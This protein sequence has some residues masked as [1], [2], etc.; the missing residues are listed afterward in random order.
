MLHLTAYA[1]YIDVPL[2]VMVTN[3]H[4][5]N[6]LIVLVNLMQ[7]NMVPEQGLPICFCVLRLFVSLMLTYT[8]LVLPCLSLGLR[9]SLSGCVWVSSFSR[10][11]VGFV[12]AQHVKF[13]PPSSALLTSFVCA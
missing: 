9:I 7:T 5:Q 13:K 8:P 4:F 2:C 11:L 6:V 3:H 1:S 12:T 10:L